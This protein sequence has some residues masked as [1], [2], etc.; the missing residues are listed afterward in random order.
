MYQA[1]NLYLEMLQEDNP[2]TRYILQNKNVPTSD[3][4]PQLFNR[5]SNI[6]YGDRQYIELINKNRG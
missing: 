2:V 6:G 3:L 5:F 4:L 1:I